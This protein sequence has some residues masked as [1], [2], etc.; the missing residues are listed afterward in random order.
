VFKNHTK[1]S[2]DTAAESGFFVIDGEV[3]YIHN[4][5]L[6]CGKVFLPAEKGT[7]SALNIGSAC[8]AIRH[9]VAPREVRGRTSGV[10]AH[11]TIKGNP[12]AKKVAG[13]FDQGVQGI[14]CP[15]AIATLIRAQ[16]RGEEGKLRVDGKPNMFLV[17]GHQSGLFAFKASYRDGAW[18]L[19]AAPANKVFAGEEALFFGPKP[20]AA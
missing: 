16:N 3:E 19:E 12:K 11:M 20:K 13:Y 10:L 5:T 4:D 2:S 1:M 18:H 15:T 8:G 6:F 17:A 7:R 9:Q 14:T